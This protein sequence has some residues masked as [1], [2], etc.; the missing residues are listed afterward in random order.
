MTDIVNITGDGD[1]GSSGHRMRLT[2]LA[3]EVLINI[4]KSC[5]GVDIV[6]L[7]E[8]FRGSKLAR[9]IKDQSLWRTAIIGPGT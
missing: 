6:N 5:H 7:A 4:F 8:A 9:V 2:D 3:D 1:G